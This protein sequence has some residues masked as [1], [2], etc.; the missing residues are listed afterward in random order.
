ML[1]IPL[2]DVL[3]VNHIRLR[4]SEIYEAEDVH[5]GILE[6]KSIFPCIFT[7]TNVVWFYVVMHETTSV[8]VF[9][10]RRNFD[11]DLPHGFL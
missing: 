2:L 8:K 10:Q 3:I 9:E 11:T 1:E 4:E 5:I 6:I 7:H